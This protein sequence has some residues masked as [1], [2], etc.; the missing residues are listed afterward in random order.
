METGGL[1]WE[2]LIV[3]NAGDEKSREICHAFKSRLPLQYLVCRTPGKNAALN[4]GLGAV[5]GDF[6]VLTDDDVLPDGAWLQ[7]LVQG[8]RRWPEQV[9]FGGRILPEWPGREPAFELE[10]SFGRWTYGICDPDLPEGPSPSFLPLGANM[11]VRRQVFLK[12]IAFD[13]RIGPNGKA[14]AMGSVTELILRLRRL[15]HDAVFL[16]GALVR[17]LIQPEQ[18]DRGWL[19]LRA[20]RQGRGETRLGD[21]VSWYEVARKAKQATVATARYWG[22]VLRSEQASAFQKRISCSL[23]RGRLYEAVRIKL[24]LG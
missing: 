16:P 6:V 12:G 22:M 7:A 23:C 11:A 3:D 9:L 21:D 8:A 14:Y 24:G 17:H 18:L 1:D 19:I 2:L 10:S 4:H 20:F 13:E 5:R 15:G